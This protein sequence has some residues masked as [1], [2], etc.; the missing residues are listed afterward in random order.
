MH[1]KSQPCVIVKITVA[2]CKLWLQK[3]H[4]TNIIY[5]CI[6]L[7]IHYIHIGTFPFLKL[8]MC[9]HLQT[10]LK[11]NL[12]LREAAADPQISG[13]VRSRQSRVL[14][15]LLSDAVNWLVHGGT[16]RSVKW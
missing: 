16:A 15:G 11:G 14:F 7:Y 5:T 3:Q 9:A 4:I 1:V 6:Y 12:H 10:T 2:F 13:G 8:I